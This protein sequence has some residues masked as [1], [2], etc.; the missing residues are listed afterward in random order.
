MSAAHCGL[1][2][3]V[4]LGEWRVQEGKRD[5]VRYNRG[6]QKCSEDVQDIPVSSIIFHPE[7]HRSKDNVNINDIMIIKLSRPATYNDYVLPICLPERLVNYKLLFH[8]EHFR[9]YK[10]NDGTVFTAIG[11]GVTTTEFDDRPSAIQQ[12]VELP[13]IYTEDC[14]EKYENVVRTDLTNQITKELHVC[15]G[16][17]K[18]DEKDTC[19]V[20][21]RSN[22]NVSPS[23][24]FQGDSGGPLLYRVDEFD[25]WILVGIISGGTNQCGQGAPSIST[26]VVN[27]VEWIQETLGRY[28]DDTSDIVSCNKDDDCQNKTP[29]CIGAGYCSNLNDDDIER[30]AASRDD[31]P[32]SIVG[33]T[34]VDLSCQHNCHCRPGQTKNVYGKCVSNKPPIYDYY[35]DY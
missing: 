32:L 13:F 14:I 6:P 10:P 4:R 7:Y 34:I 20:S 3:I 12:M 15:A 30:L 26:N 35:Y 1:V 16:G 19:K 22:K 2:D 23:G 29:Y 9:S 21:D 27:Y 25:P 28:A 17:N 8:K 24:S 5:C 11:W 33:D 18:D 31:N